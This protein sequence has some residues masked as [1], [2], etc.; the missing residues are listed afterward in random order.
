MFCT[1]CGNKLNSGDNFCGKCGRAVSVQGV[2]RIKSVPEKIERPTFNKEPIVD[3][4]KYTPPPISQ[5]RNKTTELKSE[6]R[7]EELRAELRKLLEKQYKRE[8][9]NTELFEA[10]HWLRGYAEFVGDFGVKEYKRQEK[11][12]E[13]PKGFHL[14][15]QGYTC[16]ICGNSV[17]NEQTWYDKHG[18][19]CLVC[20]KAID[21]KIIPATAASNK[22]SW[23]SAYDIEHSFFINRHGLR[24]LVKEGLLKPS[25]VLGSSGRSHVQLFFIDDNKGILPPKKLTEWPLVKFQKDGQDW[26][27]SEPWFVYKD[28]IE[29]LKDYKILDYIKTLQEHEILKSAPDLSFQLPNGAKSI[30]KI[31]YINKDKNKYN[32]NK[33]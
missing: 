11:L 33:T 4:P 3:T 13:N 24:R 25:I 8:I 6:K 30:F 17:S 31:N 12:K 22:D 19:K 15:G 10:E 29:T 1:N 23:Y 18:I 32:T 26:Y 27:H 7:R 28:P 5:S 20:Q 2:E 9:T 21:D 16:F 14:E